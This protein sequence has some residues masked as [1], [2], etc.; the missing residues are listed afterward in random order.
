MAP[1]NSDVAAIKLR[2]RVM[3]PPPDDDFLFFEEEEE[4]EVEESTLRPAVPE[5]LLAAD[6]A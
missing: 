2:I 6:V 5:E 1:R 3:N 4:L